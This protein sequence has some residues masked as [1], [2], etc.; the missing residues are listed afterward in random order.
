MKKKKNLQGRM[1]FFCDEKRISKT[2]YNKLQIQQT[3]GAELN[4]IVI[5]SEIR[6]AAKLLIANNLHDETDPYGDTDDFGDRLLAQAVR[7]N[8]YKLCAALIREGV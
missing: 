7:K 4:D 1:L 5:S 2:Q 6:D 8:N 3:G